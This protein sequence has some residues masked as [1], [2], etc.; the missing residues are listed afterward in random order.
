MRAL[1]AG[2]RPTANLH[3]GR[4]LLG[5]LGALGV[6]RPG[7]AQVCHGLPPVEHAQA[8]E[9]EDGEPR[10]SYELVPSFGMQ[11]AGIDGGDY[12]GL[13][14]SLVLRRDWLTAVVTVPSYRLR[15]QEQS[16]WGVGDVAVQGHVR[17][18]AH[19]PHSFGWSLALGLPTGSAGDDLGMGHVMTMPGLFGTTALGPFELLASLYLGLQLGGGHE[20]GHG[21]LVPIVNPMNPFELGAA[22]RPSAALGNTF[23]LYAVGLFAWPIVHG[24]ER[25]AAGPGVRLTLGEL[26]LSSE[27][28][29]GVTGGAFDAKGVLS[30][31]YLLALD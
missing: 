10:A 17:M 8:H 25:A 5:L 27:L 3:G 21:A 29:L 30:A 26:Q 20:H 14:A 23:A 31:G 16:V 22:L 12:E 13:S 2:A 18:L 11:A 24:A 7:T 6:A 9:H 1:P 28:Q 19:G 4:A 15:R